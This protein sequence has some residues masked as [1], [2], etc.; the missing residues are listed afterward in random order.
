M[1]TINGFR[2]SPQQKY[3][4]LLQQDSPAYRIQSAI[5]IE[6]SLQTDNLK[7][8]LEKV[9]KRHEIIR[10]SFQRRPGLKIPIQVI[11]EHSF[12][13]W[14]WVNL[15]EVTPQ[16]QQ[17]KLED[18]FQQEK[19]A[20]FNFEGNPV[21]RLSLITLSSERHILL[22]SL[23][24]LCADSRTLKNL[25]RELSQ[26]YAASL[27]G[28]ELS[29]EVVQYV[30]FSEWQN[31]LLEDEEVAE[32]KEYWTRQD[33]SALASLRLPFE[34]RLINA[35]SQFTPQAFE[36]KLELALLKKVEA[37]ARQY[38]TSL[39]TFLLACWKILLWRLIGQSELTV[40]VAFD[41]RKY[42]EL[43][44][45]LGLFAKF[46]PLSS[47]LTENF[48]FA[49]TWQQIQQEECEAYKYQEYFSHEYLGTSSGFPFG[50]E[51]EEQ[52]EKHSASGVFFSID[53]QYACGDRFKV[54]L[55]CHRQNDSLAAEFHYDPIFLADNSIRCLAEQFYTLVQSAASNPQTAIDQLE[56]LSDRARHQLLVE[57]N[58]T[59]ADYQLDKCVHQLF[60][61][62][63]E[64]S[65]NR[66]AAVCENQQITYSELN[67]RANQ[68]AHYL[69]QLGIKPEVIVGICVDR[70]LEAI[71]GILGILKAGGAYLP[72][73]PAMPKERLA[74]M[75]QNARTP[76]L[77]TQQH[78][79][80]NLPET[81]A[82]I[83]CLD[84]EIPS[85]SP[86]PSPPLSPENLAYVI[87]TSGS[88]GT[89]KG[90]AI[91]HRQLLNY[92]HGIQEKLNLPSGANYAT[93]STFAADL[94]NT[95]I[96][97][98][99]C[100]GGCLHIISQERATDPQ[101]IA[102]YFQQ[103]SI[104][105]LKIVPSH[106]KALLSD[107][108]ASQILPK[109]RLI[110]GGEPLM[111]N[112]IETIQKYNPDCSIFNHYGP[113]ETTVG[114][115]TYQVKMQ[116]DRISETVPL[117]RPLPN[118]QIYLLDSHLQPVPVGVAGELYIAGAGLARGYLNQ[119]ELTAEK[120]ICNSL[121]Q[122]PKTRLYKTGDLA[123]Y[124]PDGNI[125]FIDRVD[126]Q[127]KLR[128]FR[129]ELGEIEA[130]LS[131]HPSVREAVVLLQ[132]NEPE[133]QRLVAYIVAHSKLSVQDSQLI[134]SLRS[135]LK[136]K[137]PEYMIPSAFV[138]L[139]ALP[140]T[141][142]GKIDPQALPAPSIA[143]NFTDTFVGP[144]TP[145][146]EILAGIWSQLLNLKKVGIHDNFFD[147]GGHS[148]LITQL[149]AKVRESFQ[150]EFPLRVLF[151]APTVAGL[152]EKIEMQ[153]GGNTAGDR[154]SNFYINAEAI[155]D[156]AIRPETA[157]FEPTAE[158]TRILLTGATGFLGA[159]LLR[160]LLLQ[161][162]AEIY[163][164]V[165]SDN[166][167][168]AKKRIQS[169]L[170]YYSIWDEHLHYRIIPIAGDLA[171][172]LL[173]LS[174]EQFGELASQIDVI[175]HNGAFVKFTY[176]YS[177][178][179][180]SNVLGTQEILRLASQIKLKP[181]HF[182]STI[183]VFS[184]AGKSG[185]K[186]V[187]EQDELTLGEV[188]KGAYPQ[189]KWVAEK[190]VEIARDRGIPVSIYRPGRISGHSQ[191]GA[192]NSSDSL[193]RLLAGCVQLG[194]V[195]DGNWMMNVAPVD[196]VSR[197]IV[198][199]SRQKESIGKN[200][201]LVNPHS[202]YLSELVGWI[203][204]SGYP[205]ERV[206][207][208]TWQAEI[209][210]R[211]GNSPDHALYPLVGLFSEKVSEAEMSQSGTLQFDCK[212]TL[213]GLATTDITCPQ[214]DAN[215]FRTYLSYLADCGLIGSHN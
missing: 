167:E 65:P 111:W 194:C 172:P 87:Y 47:Q 179:K 97:P 68:I 126:R 134:E 169:S 151:E 110:L 120:F 89:P 95:V 207:Y 200:F 31:E 7:K 113:T 29:D 105:C 201:H 55:S 61:E 215:L 90:V 104:D 144:R 40:G 73:D 9:S 158:P 85:V 25:V 13:S 6:G 146:E 35:P 150:V 8:A 98:A 171:R 18:I 192:C 209:V 162:Q 32:G 62:Q 124:L 204:S 140:L 145:G 67:A 11:S 44:P 76:V 196:Y 160:E 203:R 48:S 199:L 49:E 26:C 182:V 64:R 1:Q 100:S 173:G 93:V 210:N 2:L 112:L 136:E 82:Q 130:G 39:S 193:Y 75:L 205:I 115:L 96:F 60:E 133:N 37:I 81:Q 123:R 17:A 202:F 77:L 117:G 187:G 80:K 153:Q 174:E 23:P 125:E 148:L 118:T 168:S 92:L 185:V 135:F 46:L 54:K 195:P 183:S 43:E 116:G 36:V 79:L 56:M 177:V 139:K 175:Y 66:I 198:H 188:L 91:E 16:E 186:A 137:L 206:C 27:H 197:A 143:A 71:A 42:E 119:P 114:V 20:L 147:L 5:S 180:L 108:N 52:L 45:A 74:L 156:P 41:G 131:H 88:T 30:Q 132:E 159:F 72:I 214:A 22:V 38:N 33:L 149:L 106:L 12:V 10:T 157:I 165:R 121:T 50:F 14:N 57:L 211:A 86:S 21:W 142:N 178:L 138:V 170:E 212:N 78:L 191:T 101:A 176:P 163:C 69:Q 164:L 83:V 190:L 102:A 122:E 181:V 155:L 109:K 28:E 84:A 129:I 19:N 152:A 103:H 99:L 3:L 189:S 154:P 15:S 24:A 59:K 34:N 141:P 213:D 127:V 94:G 53:K 51:F 107:S 166:A 161:T 4:W 208:E 184:S 58:S 128:G 63:A 70:S